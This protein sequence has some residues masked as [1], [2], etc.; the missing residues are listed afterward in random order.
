MEYVK[1]EW[2]WILAYHQ[3]HSGNDRPYNQKIIHNGV[4]TRRVKV[5]GKDLRLRKAEPRDYGSGETDDAAQTT[6]EILEQLLSEE[7][8]GRWHDRYVYLVH[9]YSDCL[10]GCIEITE[11]R[12]LFLTS[13]LLTVAELHAYRGDTIPNEFYH[14]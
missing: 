3:L 10:C 13:F 4:P 14:L 9:Y 7:W 6:T 8:L 2:V 12:S 5:K 1:D 11:A